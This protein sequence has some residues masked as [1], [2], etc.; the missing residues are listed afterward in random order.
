MKKGK[1]T[2]FK[3]SLDPQSSSS[4]NVEL[5]NTVRPAIRR[6]TAAFPPAGAGR[7]A[8]GFPPSGT[9][10][11]KSVRTGTWLVVV[12][13]EVSRFRSLVVSTFASAFKLAI[14]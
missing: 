10:R 3:A 14:N 5:S 7:P 6:A 12:F 9:G 4:P 11:F 1:L 13:A 8:A 2:S